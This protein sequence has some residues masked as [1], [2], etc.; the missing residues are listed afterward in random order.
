MIEYV[1]ESIGFNGP[2]ILFISTNYLLF[3]NNSNYGIIY[4]IGFLLTAIVNYILKG[5]FRHPRPIDN[6][7]LFKMEEKYRQLMPF[8]RYGMPSGHTQLVFY[9]TIYIYFV[10][11]NIKI[12][13]FYL[14]I[15]LLTLYQ[16]VV[17]RQHFLSQ[18]IIGAVIGGLFGYGCYK[19]TRDH[20]QGPL[21]MKPDDNAPI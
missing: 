11:K 15:S 13:V 7:M 20:L 8:E 19:Y 1:F 18:T 3:Q 6:E 14:V 4:I 21:K 12:L 5:F 9:S 17:S 16:R 10:F 2:L